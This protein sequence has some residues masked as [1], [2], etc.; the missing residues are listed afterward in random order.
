MEYLSGAGQA[1]LAHQVA[2]IF[3]GTQGHL[4]NVELSLVKRAEGE[5]LAFLEKEFPHV[6]H[7]IATKK[8]LS[9]QLTIE[10]NKA[11][12]QFKER[13]RVKSSE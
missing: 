12:A 2:V 9:D 11:A 13:F 1:R 6:L 8:A 7:E 3:L 5:W 4:D 10:L